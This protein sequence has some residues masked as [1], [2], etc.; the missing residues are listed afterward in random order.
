MRAI[1]THNGV[2]LIPGDS[3]Y[4]I[5]DGQARIVRTVIVPAAMSSQYRDATAEEIS[6]WKQHVQ[7]V[8]EEHSHAIK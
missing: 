3:R 5:R 2:M 1:N 4:L 7:Q 8:K 6:A